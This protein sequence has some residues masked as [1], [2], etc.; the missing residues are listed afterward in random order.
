[1][2]ERL[3]RRIRGIGKPRVPRVIIGLP[4]MV[5]GVEQVYPLWLFQ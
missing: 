5:I 1:M 3:L 4:L 2:I